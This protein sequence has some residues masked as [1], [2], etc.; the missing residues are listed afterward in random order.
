[1]NPQTVLNPEIIE[2]VADARI[3]LRGSQ[4]R[5]QR[6]LAGAAPRETELMPARHDVARAQAGLDRAIRAR[7][8]E[9]RSHRQ[10]AGSRPDQGAWN[11]FFLRDAARGGP[12][13]DTPR[14][15]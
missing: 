7:D 1:M 8:L 5:L 15:K 14:F 12:G 4:M 10:G 6:L 2:A 3:A 9:L 11:R 13:R